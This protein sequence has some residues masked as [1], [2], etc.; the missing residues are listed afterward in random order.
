MKPLA[1]KISEK[2]N[3]EIK[4]D[5]DG[6]SK[7]ELGFLRRCCPCA[8]CSEQRENQSENYIPL[9]FTDQIKVKKIFEVGNYAIGITWQDGHDTGIYE[10]SYLKFLAQSNNTV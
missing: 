9:F 3:L 4:W 7:I 10:F 1:I 5:N 2:K 6:K 8:T